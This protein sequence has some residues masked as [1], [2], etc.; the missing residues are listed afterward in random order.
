VDCHYYFEV[1]KV[2]SP[3]G[4]TISCCELQSSLAPAPGR[5][6]LELD[7]RARYSILKEPVSASVRQGEHDHSNQRLL[8]RRELERRAG[9]PVSRRPGT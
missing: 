7:A 2:A 3:E 4:K 1:T 5:G 8:R 9:L 6:R